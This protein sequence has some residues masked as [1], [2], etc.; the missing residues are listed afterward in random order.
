M[1]VQA[2]P[3][4]AQA[5]PGA[6]RDRV[7]ADTRR[8]VE[9][10]AHMPRPGAGR[11]APARAPQGTRRTDLR[12]LL[13]VDQREPEPQTSLAKRA[14]DPTQRSSDRDAPSRNLIVPRGVS[15]GNAWPGYA[16][17]LA[18]AADGISSYRVQSRRGSGYK[19]RPP[20]ARG[21]VRDRR[22]PF[23]PRPRELVNCTENESSCLKT[24]KTS[25]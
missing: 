14:A 18:D 21:V 2:R 6:D 11:S 12:R 5:R 10:P 3:A 15:C 9:S 22:S 17:P 24:S 4:A 25:A 20:L 13:S 16:P 8:S 7:P 23:I 19:P 1:A